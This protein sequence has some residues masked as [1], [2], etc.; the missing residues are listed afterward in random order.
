MIISLTACD[1]VEVIPTGIVTITL[2]I[3]PIFEMIGVDRPEKSYYIYMDDEFLGMMT[4]LEAL[5]REEVPLGTHV[6]RATDQ[7]TTMLSPHLRQEND[8]YKK[9]NGFI[10]GGMIEYAVQ[11]GIN[12]VKI[13][14]SCSFAVIIDI[15]E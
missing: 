9:L 10:C 1:S 11:E 12:Y 14:V 4:A 8:L 3:E 7:A 13:P 6:F 15:V 2:E 5:T